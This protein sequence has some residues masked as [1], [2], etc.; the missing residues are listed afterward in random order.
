MGTLNILTLPGKVLF[1]LGAT[2]SFISQEFVEANGI[3]CCL[4]NY[5]ITIQS[6]GGNILVNRIREQQ[7]IMICHHEYYADLF[8]IPMKNIAVILGMDWLS[9]HEAQINYEENTV[10]I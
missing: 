1:D 5:P 8:V 4:L 10:S 3:K 2:T 7:V 9:N 6:A